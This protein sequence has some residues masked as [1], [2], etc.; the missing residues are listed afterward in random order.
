MLRQSTTLLGLIAALA[1]A[2]VSVPLS[3]EKFGGKHLRL[4]RDDG[5]ETFTLDALNNITG[6]GYY[7]EFEIGS[8]A[9]KLSFLLDTGS[10]DTW[11]NSADANLCQSDQLQLMNG[12]CQT[13]CK[14]IK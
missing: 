12:F 9:Q 14:C 5:D 11:V 10:S 8:P 3:R 7:S 13:T 4:K 1:A 6:G 2:H